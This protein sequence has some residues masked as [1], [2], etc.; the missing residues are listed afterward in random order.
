MEKLLERVAA[1]ESAIQVMQS[2][3]QAAARDRN[4]WRGLAAVLALL[5]VVGLSPQAGHAQL[6]IE[7][8]V[9][10]LESKLRYLVTGAGAMVISGAN[11]HIRSGTGK[12]NSANGLGNLILGYNELRA[13]NSDGTDPN[14]RTGSHNLVL[15]VRNSYRSYG[16]I[17][18]GDTNEVSGGFASVLGGSQNTASAYY[19]SVSGGRGNTASGQW[20]SVSGGAVNLANGQYASVGGG[21][22]NHASNS[23]ASVSGGSGNTASGFAASVSGGEKNTASAYYASV[24]GGVNRSAPGTFDWAAGG[25][26]QQQ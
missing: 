7:Q 25:L 18:A 22:A 23:Y 19:A 3:R 14:V 11:L 12:T 13:L 6:T 16:G 21:N 9:A 17:V 5:V 8:R 26:F 20:S 2:E 10:V 4:R 1:L 24:S 15:G